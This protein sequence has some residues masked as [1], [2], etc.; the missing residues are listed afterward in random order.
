MPTGYDAVLTYLRGMFASDGHRPTLV[1]HIL[2]VA[3]IAVVAIVALDLMGDGV[4]A[5]LD[6]VLSGPRSAP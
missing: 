2:V 5:A 6:Q 1:E 3:L 4:A